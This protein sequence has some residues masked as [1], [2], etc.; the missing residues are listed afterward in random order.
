MRDSDVQR[1]IDN[2]TKD[3]EHRVG[4]YIPML[5][6]KQNPYYLATHMGEGWQDGFDGKPVRS[7]FDGYKLGYVEGNTARKALAQPKHEPVAWSHAGAMPPEQEVMKEAAYNLAPWLSAALDDP[8]VCKEYKVVINAWFDA[9]MPAPQR[10][11]VGLTDEE[12]SDCMDMSIQKT[13]RAI[14]AKLKEKNT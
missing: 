14:E 11:W 5:E 13:C 9:A 12:L 4:E 2:M 10:T 1:E 7:T 6:Q 3:K 8:K